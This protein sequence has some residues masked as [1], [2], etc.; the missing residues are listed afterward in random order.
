MICND[1][2][3]FKYMKNP[4]LGCRLRTILRGK[5]GV[6]IDINEH[7]SRQNFSQDAPNMGFSRKM[8]R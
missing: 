3:Q 8:H 5:S 2:P 1:L 6:Y 4:S 7:F